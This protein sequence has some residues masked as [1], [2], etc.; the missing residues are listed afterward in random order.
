M[1]VSIKLATPLLVP[2][3]VGGLAGFLA[4][5][6]FLYLL[7]L[8]VN[9]IFRTAITLSRMATNRRSGT[10]YGEALLVGALPVVGNLAF[11]VQMFA[12]HP[13]L[14]IF[15]IRDAVAR[16]SRCLPIY[17]GRDSRLEIAAI[18][19]ANVPV[20]LLEIGIGLTT[21]RIRNWFFAKRENKPLAN[22]DILPISRWDRLAHEQL[23]LLQA[24][25]ADKRSLTERIDAAM[26]TDP[27]TKAA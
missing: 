18:Q 4:T 6:S 14:S 11:P 3:K 27:V 1:H 7:P 22:P 23:Q 12:S 8:L 15:L 25:E 19:A 26:S 9:P 20:E 5:G 16:L 10:A 21:G 2:L 24:A 17:G 13:E